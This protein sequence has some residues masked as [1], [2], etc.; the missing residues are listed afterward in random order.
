MK[1]IVS[2]LLL[3]F[4]L[5]L[6]ACEL[7]GQ[8]GEVEYNNLI[9]DKLNV[10]S[11][12]IEATAT[13]YNSTLPDIVTEQDIIETSEMKSAYET[14]Q[15]YLA[16]TNEL[17]DLESRNVEQQ[18]AVRAELQTY[19]TAADLYLQIFSEMLTY[20]SSSAQQEDISQVELL[21]EELHT[22]YT[23]FIEAN[24]D[25]VDV[26]ESFIAEDID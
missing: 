10:T 25:L 19:L 21:D 14:A 11:P 7:F 8:Y 6:S 17:L 26:L 5:L 15:N 16:D 4:T 9:V 18:N 20:Y 23:T 2:C 24:N 22:N 13:L 12:A 1:K 3:V